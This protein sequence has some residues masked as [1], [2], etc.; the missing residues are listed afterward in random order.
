[1]SRP[2]MRGLRDR[3]TAHFARTI[4]LGAALGI[5][6]SVLRS[7]LVPSSAVAHP[8]APALL[9]LREEATGHVSVLWKRSALRVP[10]SDL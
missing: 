1:M 6:A 7:P 3:G 2:K 8:L 10:G 5:V 9:E 4:G